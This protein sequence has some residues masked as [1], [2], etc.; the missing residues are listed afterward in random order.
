MSLVVGPSIVKSIVLLYVVFSEIEL[1][2][3][4]TV[5]DTNMKNS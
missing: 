4:C 2:R 3:D 1:A 5:H